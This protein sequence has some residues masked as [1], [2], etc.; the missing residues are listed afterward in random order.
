MA[1]PKGAKGFLAVFPVSSAIGPGP[2]L[3]IKGGKWRNEMA[4]SL[5]S[6]RKVTATEPPRILLYGVPGIGKTTLAAEF[7]NPVFIQ[8]EQGTPGDL[9]LNSFG[10]ISSFGDVLDAF[11]ALYAEEHDFRTVVIDTADALEPLIWKQACEENGWKSIEDPGYG[12]GYVAAEDV[13]RRLIEAMNALRTDRNMIVLLLAHCETVRYEP[14]GMEPYNRYHI[15]LHK[16]GAALLSE[17][18]DLLAFAN[19]DVNIKK[20]DVGFNKKTTHAE[21]G[22]IRLIHTEERPAFLA[23]NRYGMPA[24]ITYRR[25]LG[26]SELAKY[27]PGVAEE[28]PAEAAE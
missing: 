13:W 1:C 2:D 12:K 11:G 21:G 6:L 7:P 28:A 20:T 18:V 8:T 25:G 3:E 16:R 15:K 10:T 19:Y 9:E 4:I 5:A 24:K 23:K 17:N 27:F 14:P 22:G 26:Y